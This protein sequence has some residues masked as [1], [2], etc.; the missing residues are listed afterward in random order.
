MY[1]LLKRK[2]FSLDLNNDIVD[3]M[4][5]GKNVSETLRLYSHARS[6]VREVMYFD[7]SALG[8]QKRR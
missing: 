6:P 4:I 8:P 2:I 5:Y 7:S 3:V 1:A